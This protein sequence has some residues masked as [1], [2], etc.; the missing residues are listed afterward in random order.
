MTWFSVR[1]PQANSSNSNQ[2]NSPPPPPPPTG[3]AGGGDSGPVTMAGG[4]REWTAAA[5][6]GSMTQVLN[7]AFR[8]LH[9]NYTYNYRSRNI[10]RARARVCCRR[11]WYMSVATDGS[12]PPGWLAGWLVLHLCHCLRMLAQ[13][14]S[15]H[16]TGIHACTASSS[17][18]HYNQA[19]H[20]R[21]TRRGPPLPTPY[22]SRGEVGC[23]GRRI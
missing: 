18:A 19:T 12:F 5:L 21:F 15:P 9:Y 11:V 20:P 17:D 13:Q 6:L 4:G 3:A 23:N 8:L 7:I 22:Y 1:H 2:N 14:T 10:V 16:P